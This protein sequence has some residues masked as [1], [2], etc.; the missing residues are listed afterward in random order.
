MSSRKTTG[1]KKSPSSAPGP[2]G[3]GEE[4]VFVVDVSSFTEDGFV[5]ATRY[6]GDRVNLE[7]DDKGDGVFLTSEMAERL[8]VSEGSKLTLVLE[9][10]PSQAVDLTVA[11]V[12]SELRVSDAK[13]YYGVGREGG[14]VLRLRKA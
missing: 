5:G 14:A 12:G 1:L 8:Q 6:R 2:G 10:V 13:V 3:A 4:L 7:F 9:G 11:G